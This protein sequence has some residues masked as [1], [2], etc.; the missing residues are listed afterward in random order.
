MQEPAVFIHQLLVV[1]KSHY[2]INI[3][4]Q[5]T[6]CYTCIIALLEQSV[7]SEVTRDHSNRR[8]M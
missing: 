3:W 5:L 1:Y 6:F 7:L 2:T 8:T 4:M